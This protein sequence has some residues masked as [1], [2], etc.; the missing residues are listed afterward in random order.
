VS[1]PRKPLLIPADTSF[2]PHVADALLAH[3]RTVLPE[4]PGWL[5]LSGLQVLAPGFMHARLLQHALAERLGGAFIPPRI[6]TLAAWLELL[7]PDPGRPAPGGG[8]ERLMALYAELRRHAWLKKL[9]AARR[10]TDLL[11]LAETLLTLFDELSRTLLPSVHDSAETAEE[12]WHA[13]LSQLPPSAQT[14][15]SDE[16]QMVWTLWKTQL[17]GND[18]CAEHFAR[19]MQLA[20]NARQPLVW[21]AAT[22]PDACERAFL[23]AYE[24]AQPVLIVLPDWRAT[25]LLPACA[26]AWREALQEPVEDRPAPQPLPWVSLFAA[27]SMEDEAVGGARTILAWLAEGRRNIAIVAQDRVVA[28]RIRALL[29]RAEVLVT[30]ETGWKLST[31]RAAASL[32]A[33][34]DLV[35]TRAGTA[36]LLDLLKSP[37]V[38]AEDADKPALVLEIELTLR[39]ANVAGGWDAVR[40]A[41]RA[42]PRAYDLAL[43]WQRLAQ[44]FAGRRSMVEWVALTDGAL[45]ELGMR[46]TLEADAAGVQVVQMLDRLGGECARVAAEFSFSEWRALVGLQMEATPFV[47]P[48]VDDRVLM[49]PLAGARLRSF[50]AVLMVGADAEHLPS[51]QNETLFFASAVRRELGLQT[52]E[53]RQRQQLRDFAGLLHANPAVVLSW[54][55]QR[56]GEPNPASAWIERLQLTLARAGCGMLR[57]HQVMDTPRRLRAAPPVMPAPAAPQLTPQRLSAGG[58]NC[59]IAC[60]YQFFATRM[61]GLSGLDQ[62]SDMPEKRDYADWLHQVLHLYHSAASR[63]TVP[64]EQRETLLRQCSEQVFADVLAKDTAAITYYARWQKALPAYLAWANEREAQGWQFMLGERRSERTLDW[65]DGTV[66]LHGRIDRMD[67]NADG[68]RA[69]LNYKARSAASLRDR[70]KQGEDQQLAFHGLLAEEPV[71]CASYI[72]LEPTRDKAGD[73]EAPRYP[74]SQQMLLAHILA[75]MRAIAG[76]APLPA[77]GAEAVCQYCE[78]RGLCRKGAW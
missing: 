28:R 40:A 69:L 9:F 29:E 11:P 51:S 45:R 54:Q 5:D 26:A 19:M 59:F 46:A 8:S 1:T 77:N 78:V 41:L 58:Y 4:C 66:T 71:S 10:N 7:P 3:A 76:G 20:R 52:R 6:T 35:S 73:A 37:F 24:E 65:G 63:V 36:A 13:A 72:A 17:D 18:A 70:L 61:L 62:F 74:E 43:Q 53:S 25:A 32:A 34:F 33:W 14:L 27:T 56:D 57:M 39:A 42:A 75:S 48:A 15:L 68:E 64:H 38:L 49:L 47:A 50:D 60:P 23:E 30:D 21:I 2:W 16:G 67:C 44:C 55:S 31:T 22:E 12:L